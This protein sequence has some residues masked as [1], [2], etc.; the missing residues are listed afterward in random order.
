[1]SELG[2]KAVELAKQSVGVIE[3]SP[4]WGKFVSVY[5]KFVGIF[6][7]A[8]WCASF[9]AYKIHQAAQVLGVESKWLKGI[10]AASTSKI[11]QWA[12]AGGYILDKAEPG[13]VFLVRDSKN[14]GAFLH[15]AFVEKADYERLGRAMLYTVE[16]N[17]SNQVEARTRLN[18]ISLYV[19]VRIV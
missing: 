6:G 14:P 8:P 19:Y 3:T 12:V 17:E 2:I 4:N 18:D 9:V 1:M 13:C 16:G 10:G 7:P 11:Y 15:T 5:L